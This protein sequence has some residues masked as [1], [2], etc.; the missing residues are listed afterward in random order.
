MTPKKCGECGGTELDG[1]HGSVWFC[2]LCGR[3][4]GENGRSAHKLPAD[5]AFS[6]RLY[7]FH[8]FKADKA[9]RARMLPQGER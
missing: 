8:Q 6:S 1:P 5:R 3:S 9:V 4:I 2:N 7:D